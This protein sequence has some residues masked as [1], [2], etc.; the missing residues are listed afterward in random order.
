MPC[1]SVV[2]KKTGQFAFGNNRGIVLR[3][4]G[5]LVLEAF[6]GSLIEEIGVPYLI[7]FPPLKTLLGKTRYLMPE[8]FAVFY[9]ED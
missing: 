1:T 8:A 5:W 4:T 9:R 3:K 2:Q 7:S 6:G